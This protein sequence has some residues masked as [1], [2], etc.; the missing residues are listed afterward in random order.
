MATPFLLDAA[1]RRRSPATLPGYHCGR[2]PRNK[3]LRYPADPPP[4]E[5]IIAVMRRAGA[6]A[7]GLR[8][9]ALIVLLW[10]AGLRISEALALAESDLDRTRGAVLVRHGKGGKRREV[11]MDPWAWDHLTPWLER[12]PELPVGALLCII[13]G[14]TAARPW[15]GAAARNTLRHLAADA[16]VRRRFAPHQLRAAHRVGMARAGGPPTK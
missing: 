5:E 8:T 16:G 12:R 2:A 4:V 1:A 9:R 13:T 7:H 10:R 14:P 11:G 3:G 15:S 6:S